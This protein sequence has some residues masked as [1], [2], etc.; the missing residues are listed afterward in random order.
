MT[1]LYG[2]RD[3]GQR[4]NP[5]DNVWTPWNPDKWVIH[6]PGSPV[7]GD[8]KA[9]LRA[10]EN[11]HLDKKK[12]WGIAYNTAIGRSGTIYRLRGENRS[13][14]TSGDYESDGIKENYEAHAVLVMIS[15]GEVP[16]PQQLNALREVL[17]TQPAWDTIGHRQVR[18]QSGTGTITQCPGDF[19]IEWIADYK[20]GKTVNQLLIDVLKAQDR[21]WWQRLRE[22]TGEPGGDWK[23]WTPEGNS[24]GS[25]AGQVEWEKQLPRL[26]AAVFE[27]AGMGQ[28]TTVAP[29]PEK[30]W[31]PTINAAIKAHD[32]S[33]TAH[34]GHSSNPD[35]H[36]A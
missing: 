21:A 33:G 11:Y 24:S 35:A 27:M 22:M 17:D 16:T 13:G 32:G 19:L 31:A 20:N 7:G 30:N 29:A 18:E 10:W 28:V 9:A 6:H 25:K 12:W 14:A 2:V 3:W 34:V 23:Y 8:E 26:L 4:V 1:I 5:L 36:H 15:P